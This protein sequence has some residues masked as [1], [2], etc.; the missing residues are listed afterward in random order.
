M[1][2]GTILMSCHSIFY[3][4]LRGMY[5]VHTHT[6]SLKGLHKI[7]F[8]IV[9]LHETIPRNLSLSLLLLSQDDDNK[10]Q[11]YIQSWF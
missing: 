7:Y 1:T 10:F 9:G 11:S 3:L 6:H 8:E 4:R 5:S 2:I